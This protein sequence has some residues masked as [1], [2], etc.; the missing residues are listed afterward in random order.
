MHIEGDRDRE[1]ISH[2]Y[3]RGAEVLRQDLHP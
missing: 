1:L 3:L 2:V